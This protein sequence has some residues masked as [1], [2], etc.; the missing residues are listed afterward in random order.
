M[1][2]SSL[3]K[4]SASCVLASFRGSTYETEYASPPRSLRPC[5]TAFLN[6]LRDRLP[7]GVKWAE[8]SLYLFVERRSGNRHVQRTFLDHRRHALFSI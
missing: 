1:V 3:L 7:S 2:I 4:K 8:A 5:R 6:S